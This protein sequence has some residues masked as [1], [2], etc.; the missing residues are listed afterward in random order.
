MILIQLPI[1]TGGI[2]PQLADTI[3]LMVFTFAELW[4]KLVNAELSL[5]LG[6][7]LHEAVKSPTVQPTMVKGS[8]GLFWRTAVAVTFRLA[9]AGAEYP[10]R[11]KRGVRKSGEAMP[12]SV[13][14]EA[15]DFTLRPNSLKVI[16]ITRSSTCRN[17]RSS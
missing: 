5:V 15:L 3:S 12:W 2:V 11:F 9:V 6:V 1:P 17:F 4:V 16:P 14:T 10:M 13:P 8:S 7:W